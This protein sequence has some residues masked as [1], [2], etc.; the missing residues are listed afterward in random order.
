MDHLLK[1]KKEYKSKK[2]EET[3]ETRGDSQYIYQN[4]LDNAYKKRQLTGMSTISP[5]EQLSIKYYFIKHLI[6]L[7]IQNI[8]HIK[9]ILCRLY[10]F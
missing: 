1:R 2:F 7:K 3:H 8:M 5:E 4:Q 6:L 10:I 9:E